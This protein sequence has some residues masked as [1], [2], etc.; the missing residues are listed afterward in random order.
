MCG[1]ELVPVPLWTPMMNCQKRMSG[2]LLSPGQWG[3][4]ADGMGMGPA[5]AQLGGMTSHDL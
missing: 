5:G 3:V 4:K 1:L 2:D